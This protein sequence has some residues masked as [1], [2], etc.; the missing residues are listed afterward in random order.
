M[1]VIWERLK[2]KKTYVLC[3]ICIAT[4]LLHALADGLDGVPVDWRQVLHNLLSCLA[5]MALRHGIAN[6]NHHPP[7]V[8]THGLGCQPGSARPTVGDKHQA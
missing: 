3:L 4:V 8:R 7:L 1:N 5:L 6:G 2:G